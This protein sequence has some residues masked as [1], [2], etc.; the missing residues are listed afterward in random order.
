MRCTCARTAASP[1]AGSAR[2]SVAV[3]SSPSGVSGRRPSIARHV[4]GDLADEPPREQ[5]DGRQ[6]QPIEHQP[7]CAQRNAGR[8]RRLEFEHEVAAHRD[9][10]LVVEG[11]HLCAAQA[12]QVRDPGGDLEPVG[13]VEGRERGGRVAGAE[14]E[15]LGRRARPRHDPTGRIH[16]IDLPDVLAVVAQRRSVQRIQQQ[17]RPHRHRAVEQRGVRLHRDLQRLLGL[18]LH[19]TDPVLQRGR[20]RGPDGHPLKGRLRPLHA[21]AVGGTQELRRFRQPDVAVGALLRTERSP[22]DAREDARTQREAP[23]G[24]L[25]GPD[26]GA[27]DR[28][29]AR[30]RL[31]LEHVDETE[32]LRRRPRSE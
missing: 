13:E 24:Q 1:I 27:H 32:D 18:S 15:E 22:A 11:C 20:R 6:P 2:R 23:L 7:L 5:P 8:D 12:A 16:D 28:L 25:A 14:G 4:V 10:E 17:R 9:A 21:R 19:D 26:R 31:P 30:H 29:V 3:P